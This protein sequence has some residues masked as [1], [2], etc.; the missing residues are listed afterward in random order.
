MSNSVI[1]NKKST[2]AIEK[3]KPTATFESPITEFDIFLFKQGKHYQLFDK[4][5]AHALGQSTKKGIFFAVWAPAASSVHVFGDFNGWNKESHPMQ[6]RW[7]ES[8]IWEIA[9]TEH[10]WSG[11]YKYWIKNRDTGACFEKFD[12]FARMHETAPKTASTVFNSHFKWTDAKWMK[13]RGKDKM[14]TPVSIYEMHFGSWKRVPEDN[15]RSLSYREM[16]AELVA[17]LKQM[18][19]TH[20]EFLPLTEHPFYGSWG[21]QTLGYFA[22]TSRYGTPDDFAYLVNE[23]HKANIGVIMDW[24]PSHFPEDAYALAQ[25]DGSCL[26][27]NPDLK[28]GYHPDWKSLIF[29]YGRLE[30]RSFLISSAIFWLKNFHVDGLRVDAVASMLYLDYSRKQGEW[31][32]NA[33]GGN[34]NLEAIEFL[35]ELNKAVEN[36]FPDVYMMA[37]ESTAWQGVSRAIDAGGLGFNHKWMMGWMHD[38]LQYFKHEPIYRSYHQNKLSFSLHYAFTENFILPLSHDEVVHGKG[39]IMARMPG[40]EW[41][42][43][44]N[45]RLL[46]AYMFTHP[47]AKLL[48]MGAE[49]GQFAEWNHDSSLDWDVMDFDAYHS[50]LQKTIATLNLLYQ[51]EPALY[52]INYQQEG[53][54]WIDYND[55]HNSVFSYIRKGNHANDDLVVVGNFTPV[56]RHFYRLGVPLSGDYAE[57]FNSDLKEWGGSNLFNEGELKTEHTPY[58][59]K[60]FSLVLT[61]PPLALVILKRKEIKEARKLSKKKLHE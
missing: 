15:N 47:G 49:F 2:K 8:G 33:H 36:A 34:E 43:F 44:A 28:K 10:A 24:V 60:N 12:P 35:K 42:K 4:L 5:G 21:Y 16:A 32:P 14:N 40:D 23:L 39:S 29:N 7:D 19:F 1:P 27:E 9:V 31:E 13:K 22:P 55:A 53:F 30:V 51:K 11:N 17:Y 59:G 41:Q 46:Y 52:E 54:E 37:E 48:F 20:V 58:H 38:T 6:V 25:Y 18:N 56:P 26:F 3:A 57:I 61:L 45:A 50:S